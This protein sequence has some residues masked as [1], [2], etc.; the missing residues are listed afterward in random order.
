VR[1]RAG[2]FSKDRF[3]ID[4]DDNTVTCPAGQRV[5][6]VALRRG[7]GR[8]TFAPHCNSCPLRLRCTVARKGR[9]I[10]IHRHEALLQA[11]RAEQATPEWI[12]RYRADR[13]IVERK[14]AHFARRMGW[15]QG[16]MSRPVQDLHRCRHQGSGAQLRAPGRARRRLRRR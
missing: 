15:A 13:P 14:M 8:A 16:P 7:G 3:A 6:I 10:T 12:E 1:N 4:L 11:A 2:R 9:S 5:A